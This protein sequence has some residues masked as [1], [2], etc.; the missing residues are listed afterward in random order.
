MANDLIA[1]GTWVRLR[2]QALVLTREELASRV[3]CA[4]VTIRKIEADERK[5]SP[6]IAELLAQ[7]LGLPA[8][9]RELF[10]RV[11]RGL[12][13]VA[14]LAPPIPG[15]PV[16]SSATLM[17]L[18]APEPT[19]PTGTVTFLFTDIEGSTKRWE[20]QPEAMRVALAR[21]N[22][23][24]RAAIESHSGHVF[25]TVG[26]AFCAAF[27]SAPDALLA[28]VV[29][30]RTLIEA[31]WGALEPIRVRMA[32]HT[33]TAE[34]QGGDYLGQPLNRIARLLNAGH[35]GQILLS[36]ATHE[37]VRDHLPEGASLRDLGS[38]RLKDVLR[39]ETI[40]QLNSTDLPT[41]F[42]VLK[43][44]EARSTNLPIQVTELIGRRHEVADIITLLA[45]AR[46]I[47]LT[48]PGGTGK[49]R[50]A[51]QIG[52]ELLDQYPDGVWFIDLASTFDGA[53]V[54]QVVATAL[55]MGEPSDQPITTILKARLRHERTLLLLDNCEHIVDA[56]AD[57]V[58]DLLRAA[59][60]IAIVATSR[61][62]LRLSSEHEYPVPPLAVP[63]STT[64]GWHQLTQYESVQL[65]I[66]R[67]RTV[68]HA[69]TVTNQN[70]PAVAEI[71]VRLDGL[72]LAIELAV[73]RLK[74]FTP[75]QVLARL[76][77]TL[78]PQLTGGARDLPI[79]Q[80]TMRATI[81]WSYRLLTVAEQQLFRSLAIFVG[82]W[83][84]DAMTYIWPPDTLDATR[85][86]TFHALVE[87]SLVRR[88]ER[89]GEPRFAMFETIREYAHEQLRNHGEEAS[90]QERHAQY[91]VAL[92]EQIHPD[93]VWPPEA[94]AIKTF[95]HE[96]ENLR[97]VLRWSL[98]AHTAGM[99]QS[100]S[101]PSQTPAALGLRL[102]ISMHLYW[103][104]RAGRK[105]GYQWIE[106]LYAQ[107]DGLPLRWRLKG[108][109]ALG[110]LR[111][112]YDAQSAQELI[113]SIEPFI[114]ELDD[115]PLQ[116]W[117]YGCAGWIQH[118]CQAYHE[119]I[120]DWTTGL[121]LAHTQYDARRQAEF[122]GNLGVA[123][124]SLGQFERSEQCLR[125]S[126]ALSRTIGYEYQ[127]GESLFWLAMLM[128]ERGDQSQS[129]GFASECALVTRQSGNWRTLAIALETVGYRLLEQGQNHAGQEAVQE[130]FDL[131]QAQGNTMSMVRTQYHLG[132]LRFDAGDLVT[133]ELL[134]QESDALA[135]HHT[136]IQLQLERQWLL[137]RIHAAQGN[138]RQAR[139]SYRASLLAGQVH[140]FP[141]GV[142]F[143]LEAV[144][145]LAVQLGEPSLALRWW[146]TAEMLREVH[147]STIW[148]IEHVAPQVTGIGIA[149]TALS[150]DSFDAAWAAGRALTWEQAADEALIW[151]QEA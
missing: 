122:L 9:Q 105:E 12:V 137:G 19:L 63:E 42:P 75:E 13:S 48:G 21:H 68:Q 25:K 16:A 117:F 20:Q 99:E 92:A 101:D 120:S 111:K 33:G 107:A 124:L 104:M 29:G 113:R 23:I 89:D 76:N 26:D 47:T 18:N 5:P 60:H 8:D 142:A 71:C 128:N 10:V 61:I 108:A 31:D 56:V 41:Q 134:L 136:H 103:D 54:A 82:G 123:T 90:L 14:H 94:A 126:L 110:E 70:A 35:G 27:A 34:P 132:R 141:Y 78:L 64:S 87:Q 118:F 116:I 130:A 67:A 143:V 15:A 121:E 106:A 149:R 77:E 150:T 140:P 80:R 7:Q 151:L 86:D 69:F 72:P 51:L 58:D 84:I 4:E 98:A 53:Q 138:E 73:A 2:R 93:P 39:S 37:L 38:H 46:L 97:A 85:A 147:T 62:S 79:R 44:L 133:A 6:Q 11:A 3:G 139:Q 50:L 119:A 1:F 109:I 95:D 131:A 52:A 17:A 115:P 36:L 100:H 40:F 49:T 81:E 24:L 112:F 144:A 145:S 65:F 55:G 129:Y 66:N 74:L 88:L 83:T 148:P 22:T 45:R 30:Q 125:E 57:L 114:V 91:F 127:V 146:G 43:S 102:I 135:R 59:A 32:V 96:L 28:A